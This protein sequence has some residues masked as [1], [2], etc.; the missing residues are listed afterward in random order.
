MNSEAPPHLRTYP[1]FPAAEIEALR[2]MTDGE[3]LAQTLELTDQHH[4]RTRTE[5]R[6]AYPNASDDEIYL[7]CGLMNL[8]RAL[9]IRVCGWDPNL[10]DDSQ[11]PYSLKNAIAEARWRSQ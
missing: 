8:G 4:Q 5:M 10:P 11:Q 3:R 2:A 1:P 6:A 9:M 7:R